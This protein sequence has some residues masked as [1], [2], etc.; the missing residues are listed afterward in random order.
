VELFGI[1][2]VGFN[3]ETL[4]KVL[5]TAGVIVVVGALRRAL[6][7]TRSLTENAATRR[8]VWIRKGIRLVFGAAA[9][10]LILSIWFDRPERLAMF[11]GLLAAGA[12][13]A[14]QKA[15]L[16]LAGY[17]VI[18]FGKVF[19]IGDRIQIGDV[20]GD[21]VDVGLFKTTVM[22][23]GV[24]PSLLPNPNNWITAR[25]YTGR[26][27]TFTN[28]E[29][30]EKPTFNYSNMFDF[31]W[32]EMRLPLHYDE[33]L[34]RAEAIALEVAREATA[35]VVQEASREFARI[36]HRYPLQPADLEPQAFI[37]LTDSWVELSLRFLVKAWGIRPI[38]DAISRRIL[39]RYREEAITIASASF[40]LA[41]AQALLRAALVA[42]RGDDRGDGTGHPPQ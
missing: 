15:I 7:T 21:V 27:V 18:V 25:Q 39:A 32:E 36:R 29:V 30:F 6:A 5:L 2:L 17:F 35:D 26:V 12:A 11:T 28:S 10:L 33:D 23:M 20:R 24:P 19:D 41:N 4:R 13:V 37:R 38:K 16:S 22:E 42:D 40:E 31:L 8:E 3:D 1:R 34:E 9:V 14:S